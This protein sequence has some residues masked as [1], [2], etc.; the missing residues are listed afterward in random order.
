MRN[1]L[2]KRCRE[3]QNTHFM[4]SNFF[5]ENRTIYEIIPKNMA[6][7]EAPQMTWQYGEYALHA[8]YV[9]R[10]LP[11]LLKGKKGTQLFQKRAKF[12]HAGMK[13]K[14]DEGGGRILLGDNTGSGAVILRPIRLECAGVWVSIGLPGTFMYGWPYVD[15]IPTCSAPAET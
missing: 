8:V 4:I 6:K 13:A 12:F 15:P 11:V 5:S 7:I 2:Y 14:R 1:V 3:N 10:K 9:T